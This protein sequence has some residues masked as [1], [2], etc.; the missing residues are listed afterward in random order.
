MESHLGRETKVHQKVGQHQIRVELVARIVQDEI[1]NCR[2]II[3]ARQNAVPHG[4]AAVDQ[5]E[6]LE[7][8][9]CIESVCIGLG[10]LPRYG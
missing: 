3:A 1:D 8:V 5:D 6:S 10:D 9:E 2:R 7:R 4:W